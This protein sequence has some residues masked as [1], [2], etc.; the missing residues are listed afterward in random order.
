MKLMTILL[1]CFLFAC[2][3]SEPA[4]DLFSLPVSYKVGKKPDEIKARD[5]NRDGLP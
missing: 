1:V 2:V 3:Q 4:P 5:M